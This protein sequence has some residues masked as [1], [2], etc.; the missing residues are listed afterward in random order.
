MKENNDLD[1]HFRNGLKDLETGPPDG[2]KSAMEKQLT[3]AGMLKEKNDSRGGLWLFALLALLLITPLV[4]M[5]SKKSKHAKQVAEQ[6]TVKNDSLNSL[7]NEVNK[8]AASPQE[9]KQVD[10]EVK[11]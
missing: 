1:K 5:V 3:D 9:A 8:S 2:A 4:I 6:T 11:H 7:N 10:D